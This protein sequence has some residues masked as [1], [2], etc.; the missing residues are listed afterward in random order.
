MRILHVLSQTELTGSEVYA[1]ALGAEQVAAGHAVAY[2]S[3]K[4]HVPV[5]GELHAQPISR[6]RWPQRIK[7]IIY[8]RRLIAAEK[9][10]LV[11]AHSRAA[12]WICFWAT[13]RIFGRS[14]NAAAYV[15]T[16]HGRQHLHRSTKA[17]C[18]YGQRMIAVCE[19]V[20]R[21]LEQEAGFTKERL[22]V[23]PNGLSFN[24]WPVRSAMPAGL[25]ISLL[26]RSSGPKGVRAAAVIN[27]MLPGLLE[28]YPGLRFNLA[29]G[30]LKNYEDSTRANL[31]MLA[32]KYPGRLNICEYV[33]EKELSRLVFES[34]LVIA[35]G[36][37]AI[38]ALGRGVPVLALGESACHGIVGEANL[39]EAMASN[40]GDILAD[41]E[42]RIDIAAV[43]AALV[44][45]C[46]KPSEVAASVAMR[47]REEYQLKEVAAAVESIYFQALLEKRLPERLPIL[48]YHKVVEPEYSSPHKTYITEANFAKHLGVLDR[49][50][51]SSVTFADLEAAALGTR[52]LPRKPVMLT[53]DDGYRGTHRRA[54]PLLKRH[55][56]RAVF[57][58]LGDRARAANDWDNHDAESALISDAEVRELSAAGMEIGA[59]SMSHRHMDR[60]SLADS[61]QE[62][63]DAKAKLEALS[64]QRMISYAYPY[65]SLSAD[66]KRA[67]RTA[68]YPFGVATDSGGLSVAEDPYHVFRVNMFPH[69]GALQVFKKTLGSYRGYYRRKRGK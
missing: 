55:G 41:T 8:L 12:S 39:E 6:R 56:H 52:A 19:N 27:E 49:L 36:R 64:G 20:R 22:S 31:S 5:P 47:V 32:E 53:F 65:G 60:L 51:F 10:D 33:P 38:H 18:V 48:M 26:G 37:I 66:A 13:R 40:F 68:G 17:Y 28:K 7:N 2:V 44:G 14:P 3:D 15:S 23:I 61:L 1:A 30:P 59:H 35:S 4:L 16:V 34:S 43:A 9:I 29:G 57:Y 69:D 42:A 58:L 24:E 11:H 54:L 21:H 45:F 25:T 50:G 67:V 63:V 62:A 46:A